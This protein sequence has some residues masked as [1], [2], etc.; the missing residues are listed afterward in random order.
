[1][2]SATKPLGPLV[3]PEDALL[4]MRPGELKF[5]ATGQPALDAAFAMLTTDVRKA[6]T[7]YQAHI[8]AATTAQERIALRTAFL[9]QMAYLSALAQLVPLYQSLFTK[10]VVGM[11]EELG[12]RAA[13]DKY[14]ATANLSA[15]DTAALNVSNKYRLAS[16]NKTL[17]ESALV[18]AFDEFLRTEGFP[19]Q[20][21][22]AKLSTEQQDTLLR[23]FWNDVLEHLRK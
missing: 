6:L 19:E 23:A 13:F 17:D 18:K 3:S 1:M 15:A 12:E 14:L 5:R 2:A 9:S 20:L 8:D 11:H 7:D 21:A 16:D 10:F 4:G 22:K